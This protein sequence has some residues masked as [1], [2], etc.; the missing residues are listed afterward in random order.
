MSGLRDAIAANG[1]A[2]LACGGLAIGFAFGAIVFATNF[3]TMG[4]VSDIVNLGDWRRFRAWLL[5]IAV[6]IAG[7]HA[8]EAAGAV[9]VQRSMYVGPR[10]A[11]VGNFVGGLTFGFGMV[12]AGGCA[13]RNLARVGGGDLRAL[14][15]LV[16]LGIFAYTSIG[17]ILGPI[18]AWVEQS[19]SVML[20]SPDQRIGSI[21]GIDQGQVAAGVA[22][23]VALLCFGSR[24]FRTSPRHVLSGLGVGL[25]VVA[26]WAVT[27][28]A[29]D[30]LADR[31]TAPASLTFVR[32]IGDT[33]EWLQ[34]Y[35]A[36]RLPGF[37]VATVL[38][39]ILGAFAMAVGMGRFRLSGFSDLADLKRS[40]FG[41]AMMGIGGVLAIGC[42][43]GQGIT[44]VSTLALGSVITFAAIV[45]GG[46]IGVKA[47]ERSLAAQ[48]S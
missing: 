7:L 40:L 13:S 47:L 45:A 34:R 29:F 18:R 43:V 35:T 37:G 38:G 24:E 5:A 12:F 48:A 36:G 32:P 20:A 15:T 33:L 9:E 8:I 3:C 4:S 41:A 17:G 27:G 28:L 14:I 44:G 21:A 31:P 1:P 6:A 11:W 16:V 2:W 10:L 23:A 30:E 42:T 26:A 25:C 19:A 46:A 39:A 22:A